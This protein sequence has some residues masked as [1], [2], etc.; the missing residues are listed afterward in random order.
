MKDGSVLNR[1]GLVN[2]NGDYLAVGELSELVAW[3]CCIVG[4]CN[5]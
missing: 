1:K 2:L 3:S 5:N 4:C